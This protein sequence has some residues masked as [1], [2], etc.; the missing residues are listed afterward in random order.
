MP[1]STKF[2]PSEIEE[3]WY[4]KFN[5]IKILVNDKEVNYDKTIIQ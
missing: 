3:K 4:E 2:D 1:L 5:P